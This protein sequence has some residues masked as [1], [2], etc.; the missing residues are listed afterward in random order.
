MAILQCGWC[1]FQ[2]PSVAALAGKAS[3]ML[4]ALCYGPQQ[5]VFACA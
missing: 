5:W 2:A 3:F 1:L 4:Q